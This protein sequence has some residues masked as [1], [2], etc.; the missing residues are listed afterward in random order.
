MGTC[1][2]YEHRAAMVNYNWTGVSSEIKFLFT[3]K[4]ELS[5]PF[6]IYIK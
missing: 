2:L 5:A 1:L 6:S 3:R 4:N